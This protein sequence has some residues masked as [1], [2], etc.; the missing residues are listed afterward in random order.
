MDESPFYDGFWHQSLTPL[1]MSR[2]FKGGEIIRPAPSSGQKRFPGFNFVNSIA[3]A[4]ESV[5]SNGYPWVQT[6]KLIPTWS[7][8]SFPYPLPEAVA[9]LPI[10]RL[11]RHGHHGLNTHLVLSGD[12]TLEKVRYSLHE[13]VPLEKIK[14]SADGPVKEAPVGPGDIYLG[15]TEQ[16]YEFVE[17]HRCLSP[18]TALRFVDRGTLC[19]YNK[20]G[21]AAVIEEQSFI[22]DQ[23]RRH[24]KFGKVDGVL[25]FEVPNIH[26]LRNTTRQRLARELGKWF[27]AEWTEDD[28][29][30]M[31]SLPA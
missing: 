23:L 24:S 12:L 15:T 21:E 7:A 1:R 22:N 6:N 27:Q 16:G 17:G 14:I 29:E 10:D 19:W 18:T 9:N 31:P 28:L 3:P 11:N 20:D 13:R 5:V 30:R 8:F 25:V 2:P 26:L 4:Q